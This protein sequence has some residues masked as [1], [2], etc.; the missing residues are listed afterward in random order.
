[1]TLAQMSEAAKHAYFK[2]F[3]AALELARE[4]VQLRPD[5]V[6]A[7][8]EVDAY[9]RQIQQTRRTDEQEL[10]SIRRFSFLQSE[11]AARTELLRR[12]EA[13][14][15]PAGAQIILDPVHNDGEARVDDAELR[16]KPHRGSEED[17]AVGA[18][19]IEEIA[20][21]KIA[22]GSG[23]R[24]RFAGMCRQDE[25]VGPQ[26]PQTG[27]GREQR[28]GALTC[29]AWVRMEVGTADAVGEHG[30]TG[31]DGGV[32]QD[33]ARALV[34][35]TRSVKRAQ[36]S[37][38]EADPRR[39]GERAAKLL[40]NAAQLVPPGGRVLFVVCSVLR[41][42]CEDVVER[43]L[44]VLEPLPF[45]APEAQ[46]VAGEGGWQCRLLPQIHG[47]DAYFVASFRRR[48]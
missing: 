31:E 13:A 21:V 28:M 2:D 11:R 43:V 46:R 39:L 4:A 32:V 48:A 36:R 37:L 7:R 30:V 47:T 34:R 3:G 33:V 17:R 14:R 20:V 8:M 16:I 40:C 38:S 26:L 22:V 27:Q 44:H 29:G 35:V 10:A 1:M 15:A 45:E 12:V 25:H 23:E 24:D 6:R 18:V 9:E 19:S 41:A 5:G 42:E